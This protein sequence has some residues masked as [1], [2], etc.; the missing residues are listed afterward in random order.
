[1]KEEDAALSF[2]EKL[3]ITRSIVRGRREFRLLRARQK[4][5]AGER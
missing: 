4:T 5:S 2:K 3:L 1:M